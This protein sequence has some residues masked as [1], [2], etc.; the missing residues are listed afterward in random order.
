M[1][2]PIY[3]S[4]ITAVLYP[5]AFMLYMEL[6]MYAYNHDYKTLGRVVDYGYFNLDFLLIILLSIPITIHHREN[7]I[8]HC[9]IVFFGNVVFW[10]IVTVISW[11]MGETIEFGFVIKMVFINDMTIGLLLGLLVNQFINLFK[12]RA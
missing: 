10:L 9:L 8:R 7:L 12:R 3:T 4:I 1:K 6:S 11:I 5:V 2:K